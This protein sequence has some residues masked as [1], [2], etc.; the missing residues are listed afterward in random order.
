MF[1]KL[2]LN[3]RIDLNCEN[4]LF[5]EFE[6][7]HDKKCNDLEPVKSD[8][9]TSLKCDKEDFDPVCAILNGSCARPVTLSNYCWVEKFNCEVPNRRKINFIFKYSEIFVTYL[10]SRIPVLPR[11][12]MLHRFNRGSIEFNF[13]YFH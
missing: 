1:L 10:Y 2:P 6:Y 8:D 13:F 7:Y 9:C 12:C 4:H 11:R 3:R 5:L